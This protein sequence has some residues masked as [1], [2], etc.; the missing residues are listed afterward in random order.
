MQPPYDAVLLVCFG[1]PEKPDDVIPF[2]EN[3]VRGKPVPEE[4]LRRVAEHYYLF[5][6][7]S[8]ANAQNRALLAALIAEL[9]GQGLQLPVYWGNRH[10]HPLLTDTLQ[11]MADD[12]VRRA[13]AF[14]PSAFGSY[15]SCREYI[16]AIDAARQAVGP[17]APEVD[18]I[19]LFYNHPDYI[20]ALADRLV[21][22]LDEIPADRRDAARVV[23]SAHSIPRA[24]ADTCDYRKQLEETCR[25]VAERVDGRPWQLVFQSRSGRP[26]QPWLEP[27]VCDYLRDLAAEGGTR[28]VVIVPLSA[29][30]EHMEIV[31]DLDV[32]AAALCEQLGLNMVRAAVVGSHPRLVGMIRRLVVERIEGHADRP[33]LGD[34]G[35]GHDVCP[36]DCCRKG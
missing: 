20:E 36:A 25:L 6:G 23:Y 30:T 16:E 8:P 10:W 12:G 21:A 1:G 4:R 28:D 18:K 11:D 19:R 9:N 24:M 14:V 2:L 35:P 22:A 31:F 7:V 29:V 5:D 17:A 27:D 34:L 32:Q 15:S 26:S 3:V 13:L 33:A